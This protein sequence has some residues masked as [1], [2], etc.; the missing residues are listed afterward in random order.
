MTLPEF[1]DDAARLDWAAAHLYTGVLSDACDA[2]GL[3]DR[4]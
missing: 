4:A 3:R 2:A 1:A